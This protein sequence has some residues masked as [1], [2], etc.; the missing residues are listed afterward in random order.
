MASS[1]PPR[2]GSCMAGRMSWPRASQSRGKNL[3]MSRHNLSGTALQH[4]RY[5]AL[6]LLL[7][8]QI[9]ALSLR[10]WRQYEQRRDAAQRTRRS[11][12]AVQNRVNARPKEV[13]DDEQS[14]N[15]IVALAFNPVP[16]GPNIVFTIS[17]RK[18]PK[19]NP[20]GTMT[21][22]QTVEIKDGMVFDATATDK[23]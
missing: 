4:N 14:F 19:E 2:W 10:P 15:Q 13:A 18:G 11:H 17:Y 12:E 23:S 9:I 1:H 3:S 6:Y 20:E 16:T 21:P 5:I 7:T 22:G 8:R